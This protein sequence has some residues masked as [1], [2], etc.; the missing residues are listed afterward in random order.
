MENEKSKTAKFHISR[1]Q[2][3]ITLMMLICFMGTGIGY[4]WSNFERT[5]IGYN[6]SQLN[7]EEMRLQEI[8]QKL[9]LEL[10]TLK[11]PQ[12]LEHLAIQQ[13]G[14]HSPKPEQIILLP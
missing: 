5:Q 8:N 10:A 4:V 6:L 1:R 7:K 11:S 3:I 12:N 13:L 14:L 9:K 2:V